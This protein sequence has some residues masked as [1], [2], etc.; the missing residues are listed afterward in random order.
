MKACEIKHRSSSTDAQKATIEKLVE[1]ASSLEQIIAG[2][3][4]QPNQEI[5]F[6]QG[7]DDERPEVELLG[8]IF[9]YSK[10]QLAEVYYLKEDLAQ[11][12]A[13]LVL[14]SSYIR[15]FDRDGNMDL[16]DRAIDKW[17][18]NLGFSYSDALCEAIAPKTALMPFVLSYL[19]SDGGEISIARGVNMDFDYIEDMQ[20]DLEREEINLDDVL[21]VYANYQ[22]RQAHAGVLPGWGCHK[23]IRLDSATQN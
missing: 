17:E 14:V 10:T 21:L 7:V 9:S 16:D 8:V 2:W 15:G 4:S 23:Y 1:S 13:D 19:L 20:A 18:E 6:F 11:S 3:I 12:S 22:S 5:R